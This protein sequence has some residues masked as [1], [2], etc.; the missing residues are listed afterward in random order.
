[1]AKSTITTKRIQ[2][3]PTKAQAGKP[4]EAL[5]TER[6]AFQKQLDLLR[7]Y[8]T[9]SGRE[10]KVVRIKE[11]AGIVKMHTVTISL[12]NNFF[13]ETGLLERGNGG[14]V[15]SSEVLEFNRAYEWDANTA[16]Q[17]L[18]PLIRETWFARRLIPKL[19]FRQMDEE[20][21]IT[22]L[23][24]AASAG[25]KRKT[26]LRLLIDYLEA[27]GLVE[28]DGSVIRAAQISHKAVT[29]LPPEAQTKPSSQVSRSEGPDE[30]EIK[31]FKPT[32]GAVQFDISVSVDMSDFAG[33]KAD[34]ITAFFNGIAAVLAAR[35]E[36]QENEHPELD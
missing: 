2:G 7:A 21:I 29:T 6:I 3:K 17:K 26:Q 5:P 9:A 18:A 10:G 24:E 13:V 16:A 27:S 31:V 23:A 14:F 25:P 19:T 1:M 22:D 11:V 32:K 34:R 20:E 36:A 8:A 4:T 15:S 28:H 33:W 12:A 35:G 30:S